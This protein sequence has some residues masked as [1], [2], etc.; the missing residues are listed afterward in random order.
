MDKALG[1]LGL[2]ARAGKLKIGAEDCAKE[3]RRGRGSLLAAA[4]DAAVNTLDEARALCAGREDILLRTAYTKRD[5]ARAVGRGNPVA[6]VLLC[7]EG[8]ARAFKAAAEVDREQ[9]ERV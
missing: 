7:D 6:V 3:L 1:Y 2:A 8:L 4:S 5:I 9:E